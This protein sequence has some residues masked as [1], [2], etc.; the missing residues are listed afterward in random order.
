MP[1][2][3]VF[4]WWKRDRTSIHP[5]TNKTQ[6]FTRGDNHSSINQ[7]GRRNLPDEGHARGLFIDKKMQL[8]PWQ[9]FLHGFGL[10][11]GRG[12]AQSFHQWI[13]SW[14]R[15]TFDISKWLLAESKW[16]SSFRLMRMRE[17][18][19]ITAWKRPYEADVS[20]CIDKAKEYPDNERLS[21][22]HL[23]GAFTVLLVG[24]IISMVTFVI[25]IC[26]GRRRFRR[27]K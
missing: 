22:L 27:R 8:S 26:T 18:G 20:R 12:E 13:E 2:R 25:E 5:Y 1:L 3:N 19:L 17:F 6:C 4:K 15:N 11:L 24:F 23:T 10:I 21:L 9:R 7:I 16:C 14:A